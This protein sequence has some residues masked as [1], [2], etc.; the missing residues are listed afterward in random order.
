MHEV[1]FSK[2]L[3]EGISY[4]IHVLDVI[5]E[6]LFRYRVDGYNCLDCESLF[7]KITL[8]GSCEQMFEFLADLF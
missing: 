8:V 1:Y 4:A 2:L 5:L 7:V 3:N 6:I